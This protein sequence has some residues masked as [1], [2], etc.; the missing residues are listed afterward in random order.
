MNVS[1]QSP[2]WGDNSKV[3]QKR[4]SII[5][6]TMFQSPQWGDNSK[7]RVK[8]DKWGTER[9]QSPQWGDNSKVVAWVLRGPYS[10]FSPRNGEII[11]KYRR[12]RRT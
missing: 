12:Y 1:F 6:D 7:V 9:F 5:L 4:N 10:C 3:I 2:Q 11:L 8:K